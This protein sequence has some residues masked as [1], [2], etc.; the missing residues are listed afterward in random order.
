MRPPR[1]NAKRTVKH[2]IDRLNAR[3]A[4]LSTSELKPAAA[5]IE[6]GVAPGPAEDGGMQGIDNVL[7]LPLV[8]DQPG[9]AEHAQVVRDV[10]QLLPQE[11]GQVTH[12]LRAGPQALD[13]P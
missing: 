10:G 3:P 9:M 1:R 5:K 7:A 6:A 12:G 11:S 13:D 8:P 2:F 4:E